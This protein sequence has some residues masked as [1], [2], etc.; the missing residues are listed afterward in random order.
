MLPL[1]LPLSSRRFWL[2]FWLLQLML[3]ILPL[4]P[5]AL[6]DLC[7]RS[8]HCTLVG[9]AKVNLSGCVSVVSVSLWGF[10]AGVRVPAPIGLR[11]S[12]LGFRVGDRAKLPLEALSSRS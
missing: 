10:A 2:N 7:G 11:Y 1:S 12:A 6:D 3:P 9:V 8:C 4:G 5:A